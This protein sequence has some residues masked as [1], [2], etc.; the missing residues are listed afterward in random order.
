MF[1]RV[2]LHCHTYQIIGRENGNFK[3]GCLCR[4]NVLLELF[5]RRR[6]D[7]FKLKKNVIKQ[8]VDVWQVSKYRQFKFNLL[9]LPIKKNLIH[10]KTTWMIWLQRYSACT[11]VNS[12]LLIFLFYVIRLFIPPLDAKLFLIGNPNYKI[13]TIKM[14]ND[15]TDTI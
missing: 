15:D 10:I 6:R 2:M 1:V 9:S 4:I 8:G 13:F 12:L 7:Y 5:S 14:Y 3:C 11:F